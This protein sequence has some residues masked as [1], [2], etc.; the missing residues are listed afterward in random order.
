MIVLKY[1][2]SL[3]GSL[4]LYLTENTLSGGLLNKNKNIICRITSDGSVLFE[5]NIEG[6]Y[7]NELRV[8]DI[9]DSKFTINNNISGNSCILKLIGLN[10]GNF[11]FIDSNRNNDIIL[12][13]TSGF[14]YNNSVPIG[15]IFNKN[16]N[17]YNT[18]EKESVFSILNYFM[19]DIGN[20]LY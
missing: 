9:Y 20:T 14:N 13:L 5:K 8:G 3:Y 7:D 4:N 19:D 6:S 1:N 16:I 15:I 10:N 11:D 17:E 18:V 12:S 2:N